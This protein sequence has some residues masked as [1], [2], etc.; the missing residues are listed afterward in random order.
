MDFTFT[1][2]AAVAAALFLG[3]LTQ[4]MVGFASGLVV[5][6]VALMLGMTLPEAVVVNMV[7]AMVQN[8]AGSWRLWSELELRATV[9]PI[10]LRWLA[11][12]V[13]IWA[14]YQVGAMHQ[15]QAKQII[16]AVLLAILLVQWFW[17][18]EPRQTIH[19]AWDWAAFLTSGVLLGFC[20]MG[21]PPIV[22][23][24][25]A[26]KW[27]AARS[28]AFLFFV[29]LGGMLPQAGVMFWVFGSQIHAAT[30]LVLAGLPVVV[31]GSYFGLRVGEKLP[32][33]R[34]RRV[35][36]AILLA[37]ALYAI[38][39]PWIGDCLGRSTP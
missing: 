8:V 5:V 21:G 16:G 14:L 38:A 4:G 10:V 32:K 34:L 29:L 23:W 35:T 13:G 2:Y 25:M 27:S 11:M 3:A 26:H 31:L 20:S 28:R 37:I 15:Q 22:L 36:F 39:G 30:V 33:A 24:V 12:P 17:R 6:P 1:Q 18:V 7:S 9:R 19:A